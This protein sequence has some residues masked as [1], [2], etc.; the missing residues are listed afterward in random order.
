MRAENRAN[1]YYTN[2]TFNR[3]A[4]HGTNKNLSIIHAN[5]RSLKA[6][7]DVLVTGQLPIYIESKL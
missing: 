4:S 3:L 1:Q 6:N 5:I 7:G 2:E